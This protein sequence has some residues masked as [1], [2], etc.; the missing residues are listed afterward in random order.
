MVTTFRNTFFHAMNLF[1]ILTI[2]VGVSFSS[3]SFA[4]ENSQSIQIPFTRSLGGRFIPS[5]N[6]YNFTLIDL[7]EGKTLQVIC[8]HIYMEVHGYA[9]TLRF[10]LGQTSSTQ[11]IYQTNSTAY[12]SI[13]LGSYDCNATLQQMAVKAQK[14]EM[15]ISIKDRTVFYR[16][17]SMPKKE[18]STHSLRYVF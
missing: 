3:T 6:S 15:E 8:S 2:S 11:E 5:E 13:T 4:A 12:Y 10:Y 9:T 7:P 18:T 14:Q 1:S 16:Y 17:G